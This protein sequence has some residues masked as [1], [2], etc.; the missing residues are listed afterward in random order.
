MSVI[1][2][3]SRIVNKVNSIDDESVLAEIYSLINL[4]SEIDMTY[5]LTDTERDAITVGLKDIESGKVVTNEN[6]NT[7]IKEWLKK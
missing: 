4:Q 2:L 3:K 7:L 1:E 5:A 6:A